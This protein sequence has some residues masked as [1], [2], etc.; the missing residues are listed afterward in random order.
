M[1]SIPTI[2]NIL[3]LI[4]AIQ[5]TTNTDPSSNQIVPIFSNDEAPNNQISSVNNQSTSPLQPDAQVV[6]MICPSDKPSCETIDCDGDVSIPN[7]ILQ[8]S[9][10]SPNLCSQKTEFRCQ[11]PG[12]LK[13]CPCCPQSQLPDCESPNCMAQP[14]VSLCKTT[15]LQGCPCDVYFE[16]ISPLLQPTDMQFST[17]E[18]LREVQL[19][20]QR[21][22]AG[23]PELISGSKEWYERMK[24]EGWLDG[25]LSARTMQILR[26]S[27]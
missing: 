10:A 20:Y 17:D 14:L 12:P 15:L 16:P 27:F 25:D 8:Y 1:F 13:T 9:S 22:T 3:L 21:R 11:A 5:A 4:H 24:K 23:R 18:E 2:L 26:I 7:F 19:D 6:A